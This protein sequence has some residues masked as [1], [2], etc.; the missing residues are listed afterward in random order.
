MNYGPARHLANV[1]VPITRQDLGAEVHTTLRGM[2]IRGQ[3]EAGARITETGI[4]QLLG[5]SRTPVREAFQRLEFDG[6]LTVRPGRSPRVSLFTA[7]DIQ[8]IY[9]LIAVLEGLAARLAGP[10]L[11][12]SDLRYMTQL[13]DEMARHARHGAIDEL[14]DADAS[15]HG[16]LHER[17]GSPRLKRIVSD[18]RERMERFEYAF[19]STP[20]VVRASLQRHRKLVRILSSGNFARAERTLMKQWD[21][22]RQAL[23]DIV[24]RKKLI[25]GDTA[26]ASASNGAKSASGAA[27][28]RRSIL[29]GAQQKFQSGVANP[30]SRVRRV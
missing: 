13:T 14:I 17:A 9:P 1:P 26:A 16:V 30:I 11:T 4:A 5:V 15:F 6:L 19:F 29:Y 23:L 18:L 3:F 25:V 2:I 24:R 7:A 28:E 21:L 12:E 8:E 27:K 20:S 10:R 22:G